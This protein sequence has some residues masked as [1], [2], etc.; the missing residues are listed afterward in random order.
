MFFKTGQRAPLFVPETGTGHC[1]FGVL[2]IFI[3]NH[4]TYRKNTLLEIVNK[5]LTINSKQDMLIN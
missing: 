3:T 2:L 1:G 5:L 4:G